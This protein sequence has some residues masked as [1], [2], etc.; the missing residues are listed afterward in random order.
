MLVS[1]GTEILQTLQKLFGRNHKKCYGP[2]CLKLTMLLVDELINFQSYCTPKTMP[3][4]LKKKCKE[5][6]QCKSSPEFWKYIRKRDFVCTKRLNEYLTKDFVKLRML[7]LL[8]CCFTSM[9]N[10]YGH[11]GTVR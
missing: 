2:S 11:V 6:L 8:Y 1:N 5:L 3:F 9:V 10:S 4:L 7:L